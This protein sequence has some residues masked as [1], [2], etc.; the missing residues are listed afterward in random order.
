MDKYDTP[1]LV[2][3]ILNDMPMFDGNVGKIKRSFS[4]GM[5]KNI[6]EYSDKVDDKFLN[7]SLSS[8][9][10]AVSKKF[11]GVDFKRWFYNQQKIHNS[12]THHD[13]FFIG[14]KKFI[15]ND[16]KSNTLACGFLIDP[17]KFT[18]HINGA[19][20]TTDQTISDQAGFAGY[21]YIG[22]LSNGT[23]GEYYNRSAVS[24]N[25][26]TTTGNFRHGVYDQQASVPTNLMA[27]TGSITVDTGYTFKSFTEFALTSV[28]NYHAFQ[29]D[30]N[31]PLYDRRL[32]GS[33]VNGYDTQAYGTFPNPS[34]YD[35]INY[36]GNIVA[37]IG[38]S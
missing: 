7:N 34:T 4:Q 12:V 30:N 13:G 37:K 9:D 25:G 6:M 22:K 11:L 2:K 17:F 33:A 24:R 16:M 18:S 5:P 14:L 8:I 36:T 1:F 28:V 32:Y 23:I 19:D 29:V 31:S 27:D 10:E 21:V 15:E 38:H 26:G 35:A 3:N 20:L